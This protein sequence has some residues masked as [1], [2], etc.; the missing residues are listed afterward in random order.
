MLKRI[1]IGVSIAA[2]GWKTYAGV[3]RWRATWGA[4]PEEALMPLPGDDLVEA[5][6]SIDTRGITIEAPVELV[7][8]WLV[9]MGYGRGGWYSVDQLDMRGPSANRIVDEWQGLAVGDVVPTHPGG[10][11]AVKVMDPGR[12]LVLYGDTSTMQPLDTE[13]SKIV[14]AGLAA[15]GAFMSATPR[16]F[17]ASW[18]FSLEPLDMGRTRLVE[19]VRYWGAE[20]N[21]VSN[22]A[23]SFLGFGV[24]VMMQRQMVGI[25]TRAERLALEPT[26]ARPLVPPPTN[27]DAR[28]VELPDTVIAMAVGPA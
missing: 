27:G 11:F 4:D 15:S 5:P 2:I 6:L 26:P 9:Q 8:P 16:D 22:V 12:A 21:A 13:D 24:F 10:G 18:A 19:R 25:R 1:V 14:P 28:E 3:R 7:W 23:L 20:G 17:A